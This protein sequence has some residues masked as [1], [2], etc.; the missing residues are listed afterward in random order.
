MEQAF[1]HSIPEITKPYAS[2]WQAPSN[3][4][5]IKYWGKKALQKPVNASLSMTLNQAVTT[6]TVRVVPAKERSITFSFEGKAQQDFLPKIE[7]FF[8]R[9]S[10][11]LPWV[12]KAAFTID[13]NNSFPHSAGIASSASSMAALALAVN[14]IDRQHN[15]LATDELFYKK[16]SFL[17]RLASGSASRSVY[18]G[19]AV[20]GSHPLLSNTSDEYAVA[21][22]DVPHP[23][24]QKLHD[25]IL[26]ISSKPKAVSSSQGHSLMNRHPFLQGRI[27][28]AEK[29]FERIYH[30]MKN[31]D[32]DTFIEIVE[33]EALTLH[34]LMMS[35]QK[36]FT[37]LEPETL[38]VINEIR[39]FRKQTHIPLCFTL[40]AGPNVHLIYPEMY[41][42]QVKPFVTESLIR[43]CN[44]K[45]VLHDYIGKGPRK[46]EMI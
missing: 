39:A 35:S 43:F 32:M 34:G 42:D 38:S 23:L 19:Y 20:W 44:N 33:N 1:K 13:S 16:A 22:N 11:Y 4:A 9:I 30:S 14:D 8:Q 46:I 31:G 17:A 2:S 25:D 28:Q 45:L 40:D 10:P 26:L 3:I 7:A 15:G 24:F 21:M 37:L 5:F 6:T 27:S 18:G 41:Q 29:N 12:S 36:A